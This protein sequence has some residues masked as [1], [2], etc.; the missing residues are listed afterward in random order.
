[1]S[2]IKDLIIPAYVYML[3]VLKV[4]SAISIVIT[5]IRILVAFIV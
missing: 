3:E 2:T 1:M 5:V 4:V